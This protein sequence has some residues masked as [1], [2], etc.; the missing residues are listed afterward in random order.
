MPKCIQR[1]TKEILGIY[2]G[3]G[4]KTT[5][6]WWWSEKVKERANEKQNAYA[7]LIGNR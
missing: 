5:R 4:G 7:A 1:S 6:A 3:D 2:R